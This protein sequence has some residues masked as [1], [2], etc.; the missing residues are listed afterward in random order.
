MPVYW[1]C[2][3]NSTKRNMD[4]IVVRLSKARN[5]VARYGLKINRPARFTNRKHLQKQGYDKYKNYKED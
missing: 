4:K 1:K 2:C 3:S 5:P